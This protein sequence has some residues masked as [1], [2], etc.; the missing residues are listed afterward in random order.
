MLWPSL[1]PALP[2]DLVVERGGGPAGTLPVRRAGGP[3]RKRSGRGPLLLAVLLLLGLLY[4]G[5]VRTGVAGVGWAEAVPSCARLPC[6]LEIG[7][8]TVRVRE[9]AATPAAR[10]LGLTDRSLPPGEALVF[11]WP[12][13]RLVSDAFWMFDVP[14]PLD[15]AWVVG[16][17][18]VGVASMSPCPATVASSSCPSYRSPRPYGWAVEASAGTL[19]AVRAGDRVLG[20][21]IPPPAPP[22][23]NR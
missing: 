1:A 23:R 7:S 20:R 8:V 17:R 2:V 13:R 9:V 21:S 6:A 18:V 5:A 14:A 3:R 4:S 16:D 10:E 19:R 15:V 12:G 11:D 22:K